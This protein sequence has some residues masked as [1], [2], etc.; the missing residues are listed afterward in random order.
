METVLKTV[1]PARV[2]WVRI[3]P[4]PPNK[5]DLLENRSFLFAVGFEPT[6]QRRSRC[7][8]WVRRNEDTRRCLH[9]ACRSVEGRS[10]LSHIP[11]LSEYRRKECG[12]ATRYPTPSRPVRCSDAWPQR[13]R[14]KSTIPSPIH[15]TAFMIQGTLVYLPLLLYGQGEVPKWLKGTVC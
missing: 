11:S 13:E 8:P 12:E 9:R 7:E 4:L 15:K 1:V 5:K 14:T 2:P 6:V 10:P 3:P